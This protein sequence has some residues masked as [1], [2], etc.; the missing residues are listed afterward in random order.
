MSVEGLMGS[1]VLNDSVVGTIGS[2][3]INGI[4]GLTAGWYF[5]IWGKNRAEVIVRLGTVK[6]RAAERE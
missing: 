4:F 1:F 2:W 3:Y 5:D 6:V